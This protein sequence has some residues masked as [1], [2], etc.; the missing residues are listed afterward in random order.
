MTT[1]LALTHLFVTNWDSARLSLKEEAV[2]K[3]YTIRSRFL[4]GNGEK[5]SL[6]KKEEALKLA[7]YEVVA[8]KQWSKN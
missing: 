8:E 5:L 2:K 7:G 3:L 6:E 1:Q 4:N